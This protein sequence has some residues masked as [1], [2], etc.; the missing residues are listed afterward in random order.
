MVQAFEDVDGC[1]LDLPHL[2]S[3][4]AFSSRSDALLASLVVKHIKFL[5]GSKALRL[6]D[7]ILQLLHLEDFSTAQLTIRKSLDVLDRIASWRRRIAEEREAKNPC[8][9]QSQMVPKLVAELVADHAEQ[10]TPR[11]FCQPKCACRYVDDTETQEMLQ[12]VS[13]VHRTWTSIAQ[14]QLRRRI[15]V[16]GPSRL[17]SALTSP[18]LGPWVHEL[19]FLEGEGEDSCYYDSNYFLMSVIE[20]CPNIRRLAFRGGEGFFLDTYQDLFHQVGRL[21]YVQQLVV[22]VFGLDIWDFCSILPPMQCLKRLRLYDNHHPDLRAAEDEI[23]QSLRGLTPSPTLQ[24]LTLTSMPLD[25]APLL[26]LLQP[27]ASYSPKHLE[28][29]ASLAVHILTHIPR[30]VSSIIGLQLQHD[31]RA[32]SGDSATIPSI[33][34][35]LTLQTLALCSFPNDHLPSII[36]SLALPES[37]RLFRLHLYNPS[38]DAINLFLRFIESLPPNF[39]KLLITHSASRLDLYSIDTESVDMACKAVAQACLRRKIEFEYRYSLHDPSLL[40]SY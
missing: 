33:F 18:W 39:R 27:R 2:H 9:I 38:A 13:L 25:K 24:F 36:P 34:T 29:D 11:T 12:K 16:E 19:I 20:R 26:W 30:V 31:L 17:I 23:P 4:I 3:K 40:D 35:R 28:T 5:E 8:A 6:F 37:A 7:D 21:K 10:E 1:Y 32:T 14:R 15:V 22:D